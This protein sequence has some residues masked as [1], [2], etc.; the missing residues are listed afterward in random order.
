MTGWILSVRHRYV[1][2]LIVSSDSVGNG[3]F[4][5][6]DRFFSQAVWDIDHLWKLLAQ[7]IVNSLVGADATKVFSLP[8]CVRLYRN[9]HGIPKGNSKRKTKPTA[10]Q[11]RAASKQAKQAAVAKG[12]AAQNAKTKNK[13]DP[14]THKTR[15]ELIAQI[16]T[17]VAGGL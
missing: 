14:K 4:S 6:Y 13:P 17:M 3:H 12:K 2:D 15:P 9:Q 11:M 10:A 1:T 5:D 8:I 7:L 16:M